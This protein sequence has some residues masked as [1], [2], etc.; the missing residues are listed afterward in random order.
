MNIHG[1]KRK[2]KEEKKRKGRKWLIRIWKGKVKKLKMLREQRKKREG[3][4]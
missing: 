1:L 3:K 2:I 4:L